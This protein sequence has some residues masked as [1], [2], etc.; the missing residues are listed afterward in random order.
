MMVE[1]MLGEGL[2]LDR[3]WWWVAGF[4]DLRVL[5]ALLRPSGV[6]GGPSLPQAS[7]PTQMSSQNPAGT[8]WF[9]VEHMGLGRQ[10]KVSSH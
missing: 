8:G 5:S 9:Q 4:R 2:P 1:V 6:L 3:G 7:G 10:E